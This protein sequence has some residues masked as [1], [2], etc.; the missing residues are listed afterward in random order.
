MKIIVLTPIKNEEWILD[1]F[2]RSCLFFA[3]HILI[4]DQN[5]T[6][7]SVEI[8]SKYEKVIVIKNES[9]DF[10]EDERQKLLINK[11]RELFGLHNFLL[12]LDADEI[13]TSNSLNSSGWD[14]I[15]QAALGTVFLFDKPTPLFNLDLALRYYEG[16][17]LGFVDDGSEHYPSAIHSTRIPTP[18]NSAKI[19]VE[20]I[21]FLHLCFMRKKMQFSKNRYYCILEKLKKHRNFRVRRLMYSF[22]TPQDYIK[23]GATESLDQNWYAIYEEKGID[24]RKFTDVDY[25]YMDF[26]VL[27]IFNKYGTRLFYKEPI[28]H[29]DWES[30]RLEG[31]RRGIDDI[32]LH[33]IKKPYKIYIFLIDTIFFFLNF[34]TNAKRKFQKKSNFLGVD[35]IGHRIINFYENTFPLWLY[36]TR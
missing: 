23:L 14:K 12:A 19:F 21:S 30:C 9:K 5:S 3:D 26:E 24:L 27:K 6:D 13:I 33:P 10:N 2:I 34:I 22:F 25:S 28:W 36:R 16:F 11:A 15:R 31:I 20:S 32:P 17:P 35:K 8:A 18:P 29:F 4:A 7:K 1:I